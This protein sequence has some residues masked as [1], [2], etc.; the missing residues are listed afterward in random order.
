MCRKSHVRVRT[1][2]KLTV[3]NYIEYVSTT[4]SQKSF[5]YRQNN[6]ETTLRYLLVQ[7]II[8]FLPTL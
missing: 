7:T 6:N 8:T 5:Y 1:D 3:K 4:K 2:R